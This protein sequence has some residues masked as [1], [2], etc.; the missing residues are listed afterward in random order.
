LVKEPD[1]AVDESADQKDN[2]ND[3]GRVRNPAE[4]SLDH[5]ALNSAAAIHRMMSLWLSPGPRIAP[6]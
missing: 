4:K 1:E 5:R 3:Q 6:R 2:D